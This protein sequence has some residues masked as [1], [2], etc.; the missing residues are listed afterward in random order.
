MTR[1]TELLTQDTDAHAVWELITYAEDIVR[2][3]ISALEGLDPQ[4][5]KDAAIRATGV[6][7]IAAVCLDRAGE[8]AGRFSDFQKVGEA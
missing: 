8:A 2:T 5:A 3:V 4:V 1:F 7:E 6:L